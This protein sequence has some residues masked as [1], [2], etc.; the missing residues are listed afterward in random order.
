MRW[1][2]GQGSS[3][4]M[5]ELTRSKP[6]RGGRPTKILSRLGLPPMAFAFRGPGLLSGA[7]RSSIDHTFLRQQG[8]RPVFA[9]LGF[10][11]F[12]VSLPSRA[13]EQVISERQPGQMQNKEGSVNYRQHQKVE[14]AARE[15]QPLRFG[16]ALRTLPLSRA[17]VW[18]EDLTDLRM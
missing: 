6:S 10:F 11:F 14:V 18:F 16:D 9:L 13:A 8:G 3:L 17:T 5:E 12:L 2:C 7:V 15:P 1:S 4:A